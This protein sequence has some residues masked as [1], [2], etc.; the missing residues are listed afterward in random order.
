MPRGCFH[1][2]FMSELSSGISISLRLFPEQCANS[3]MQSLE[4]KGHKAFLFALT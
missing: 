3:N 2:A 4:K 1:R